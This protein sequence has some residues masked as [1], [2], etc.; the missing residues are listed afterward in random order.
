M[1]EN[2]S[3]NTPVAKQFCRKKKMSEDIKVPSFG[4]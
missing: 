3:H 4:Q 1:V 2:Y